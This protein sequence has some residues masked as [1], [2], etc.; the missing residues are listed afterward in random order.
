MTK[1]EPGTKLTKKKTNDASNNDQLKR[2]CVFDQFEHY[3]NILAA[4][5]WFIRCQNRA[6]SLKRSSLPPTKRHV[7]PCFACFMN[8]SPYRQSCWE[9]Y[10]MRKAADKQALAKFNRGDAVATKG[11]K[12]R[13]LK[14]QLKHNERMVEDATKAA[15]KIDQWLLPETA[16]ELEAEGMEQTWRF[17]QACL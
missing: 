2:K 13:K 3:F 12:D 17:A 16:G 6:S 5:N 14:G 15:A 4:S 8:E 1:D 11:L 10:R 9:L 7:H